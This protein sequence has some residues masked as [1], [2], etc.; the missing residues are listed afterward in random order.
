MIKK[1]LGGSF[2]AYCL[3]IWWGVIWTPAACEDLL[4]KTEI[5][6]KNM[7]ASEDFVQDIVDMKK[8][9]IKTIVIQK[10]DF[11]EAILKG[12]EPPF[13]SIMFRLSR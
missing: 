12:Q 9:E 7:G 13:A 4:K 2:L 3:Y 10:S 8:E 6:Y 11:C 5:H 1:I